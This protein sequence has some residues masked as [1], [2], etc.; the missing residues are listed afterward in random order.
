MK[1]QASRFVL[2]RPLLTWLSVL[3]LGAACRGTGHVHEAPPVT[4]P[5]ETRLEPPAAPVEPPRGAAIPRFATPPGEGP[6]TPAASPEIQPSVASADDVSRAE[7]AERHSEPSAP[8]ETATWRQESRPARA[9][10]P[11]A[12]AP[13]SSSERSG[14][15]SQRSADELG[16]QAHGGRARDA[17]KRQLPEERPGLATSWGEDRYSPAR[18]VEF[19]R[20]EARRPSTLIELHY[21][22]RDG[23]RRMLPEGRWARAEK[24]LASGVT[25]RVVD[26][27]GQTLPALVRGGRV[28][29]VGALGERYAIAIEN[30]T[31]RRFEVVA[32]VDGLDVLDG[33]PARVDK[34]G[35]LVAA[36]S[37]VS[38][39][40]F[41]RS[42]DEVAA[43]RLGTVARSYAAS[44]GQSRDVGVL[45][46]AFF[47]ERRPPALEPA[48]PWYR[49]TSEDTQLRRR[50]DPFPGD[51]ARPPVW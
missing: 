27:G 37:S 41:R 50:A 5:T 43:F 22:D 17:A 45:G 3:L 33:Q 10:A 9:A 18:E 49:P 4:Y 29:A 20:A 13:A 42:N 35:Y 28:V 44:K 34:R 1:Q 46:F 51:Y 32:S 21:N 8:G 31:S 11:E 38:I 15:A 14:S 26:S 19:E 12:E 39:D 48:E 24:R 30:P 2:R 40:G 7:Q 47:D 16:W 25:V 36:Y 6:L 23:A